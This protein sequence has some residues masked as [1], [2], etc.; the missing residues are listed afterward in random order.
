MLLKTQLAESKINSFYQKNQSLA[1]H[2]YEINTVFLTVFPRH[3]RHLDK[4][5]VSV[6]D[7]TSTDQNP[8]AHYRHSKLFIVTLDQ[9]GST[10]FSFSTG[11][12]SGLTLCAH[13]VAAEQPQE[14]L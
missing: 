7:K 11:P 5:P 2:H 10:F 12:V 3:Q 14:K 6:Q 1:K 4:S 13:A 9:L 8:M